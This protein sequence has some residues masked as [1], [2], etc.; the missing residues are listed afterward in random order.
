MGRAFSSFKLLHCRFE[1]SLILCAVKRIIAAG[2]FK[3][4]P[5]FAQHCP[6]K[7]VDGHRGV[8]ACISAKGVKTLFYVRIH[9]YAQG[10]LGHGVT[11]IIY[12]AYGVSQYHYLSIQAPQDTDE[13]SRET[14]CG[15]AK[16]KLDFLGNAGSAG[17][18][19]VH[20]GVGCAAAIIKGW[21]TGGEPN[22][23]CGAGDCC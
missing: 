17:A 18:I 4:Y 11:P 15:N 20:A 22:C 9:A 6:R 1:P 13:P 23:D 16:P 12:Y 3:G 5:L 19:E 21:I 10:C 14:P 7:H 8:H 2:N